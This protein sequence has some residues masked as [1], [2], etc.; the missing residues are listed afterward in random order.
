MWIWT[1][2][3]RCE[4]DGF[5]K[6]KIP[7][8]PNVTLE[9]PF[10]CLTKHKLPMWYFIFINYRNRWQKSAGITHHTCILIDLLDSDSICWLETAWESLNLWSRD[11]V[12]LNCNSNLQLNSLQSSMLLKHIVAWMLYINVEIQYVERVKHKKFIVFWTKW[13][14]FK[15]YQHKLVKLS[16]SE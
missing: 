9:L 13:C 6:S 3:D 5:P 1:L 14:H 7:K 4:I 8:I 2:I 10:L 15:L 12:D 11:V 16:N